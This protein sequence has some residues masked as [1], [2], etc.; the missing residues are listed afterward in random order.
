MTNDSNSPKSAEGVASDVPTLIP[1]VD[2]EPHRKSEDVK[3]AFDADRY[4]RG[5]M[6][7]T[8]LGD[9]KASDAFQSYKRNWLASF[10]GSNEPEPFISVGPKVHP[11]K[12][13]SHEVHRCLEKNDNNFFFCQTRVANFQ[14]CLREFNM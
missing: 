8:S 3:T 9:V 7:F 2:I 14:Q 10:F 6:H 4:H 1:D 11:C 13:F 5:R 12:L